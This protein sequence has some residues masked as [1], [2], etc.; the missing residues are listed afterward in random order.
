LVVLAT[1]LLT[2]PAGLSSIMQVAA[3]AGINN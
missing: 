3:L 2:I 1:T